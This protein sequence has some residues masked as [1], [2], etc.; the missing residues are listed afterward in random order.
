MIRALRATDVADIAKIHSESLP[1]DLLT[2][3]GEPFLRRLYVAMMKSGWVFG[4]VAELNER[5]DG[6]VVGTTQTSGMFRSVLRTAAPGLVIAALPRVLSRP[7]L[8]WKLAQAVIYPSRVPGVAEDA[9]LLVIA[10]RPEHRGER[11]GAELVEALNREFVRR[12]ID[13]YK[14]TVYD[15]NER[16]ASFY[17]RLRFDRRGN[18]TLFGRLW[19]LYTYDLRQS[20]G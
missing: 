19:Q 17:E 20:R 13:S 14:L 18:F 3:L 5:I 8:A 12:G 4:F 6:F 11:L 1:G 10:V 15:A 2:L 9:E 16:A 7:T